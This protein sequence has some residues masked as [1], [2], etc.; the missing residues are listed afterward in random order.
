[1]IKNTDTKFSLELKN[2]DP[3]N[4]YKNIE[5]LISDGANQFL[6]DSCGMGFQSII[7]IAVLRAYGELQLSKET[8]I[9]FL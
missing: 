3:W 7:S 6:A 1:M 5:I 4:Y 8:K 9:L 2:Y